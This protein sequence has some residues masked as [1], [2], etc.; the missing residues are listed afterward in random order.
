[1]SGFH[2]TVCILRK[3]RS[4]A[5]LG[6]AIDRTNRPALPYKRP[7]RDRRLSWMSR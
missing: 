7:P 3:Y 4:A 5:L 2:S 6:M 1:M